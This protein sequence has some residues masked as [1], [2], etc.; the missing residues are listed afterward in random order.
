MSNETIEARLDAIEQQL[1]QA[2]IALDHC[3]S[4]LR[5]DTAV[6]AANTR[7]IEKLKRHVAKLQADA[8]PPGVP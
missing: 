5:V 3:R 1:E 4:D 2:T 7:E 8:T 6:H